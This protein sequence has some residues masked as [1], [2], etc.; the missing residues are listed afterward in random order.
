MRPFIFRLPEFLGRIP[1]W[2]PFLGGTQVGG[3]PIFSYGV[4]LGISFLVGYLLSTWFIERFAYERRRTNQLFLA[5]AVG[6]ILGARLLYFIA[7]APEDF[8]LVTFFQFQKG[9]LVA[10][11]GFLGGLLLSWGVA[12]LTREDWWGRADGV[13]PALALGT[14]ITRLGCFLYGC[15]FGRMSDS[16]W[17][18]RFP[19]WNNPAITPWIPGGSP[20]FSQHFHGLSGDTLSVLSNGVHPTQLLMSLNGFLGFFVLMLVIPYRKFRG[21][22][23]LVFLVYYAVTRFLV[24]LLRGDSIRGTSTLGL[25]LSTSQFV[26]VCILLGVIP[27]WF[28]L[29]RRD[30]K[31]IGTA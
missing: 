24:E 6:A 5:A 12:L 22:V 9:G 18:L 25:P 29:S 2:I 16:F 8:S 19:R 30:K 28:W 13:A 21:Q 27:L 20:A 26:S 14:G 3:R 31:K 4:M 1:D 23:L 11:G 7:S 17:V 10:Y 15:D